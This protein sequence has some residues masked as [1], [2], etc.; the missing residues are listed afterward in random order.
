MD[1]Q[2]NHV[3]LADAAALDDAELVIVARSMIA[4]RK[5]L[6]DTLPTELIHD[7]ALDILLNLFV[8]HY[9]DEGIS[10]DNLCNTTSVRREAVIRWVA[11][12]G[13]YCYIEQQGD[14]F[15]LTDTGVKTIRK[16][17]ANVAMSQWQFAD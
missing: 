3:W 9:R 14:V 5:I 12:L 2:P 10:I 1:H 16:T 6:H 4:A 17:L 8:A 11:A 7:P 15:N 13:H